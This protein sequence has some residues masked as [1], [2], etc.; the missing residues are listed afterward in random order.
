MT[1]PLSVSLHASGAENAS[2]SGTAVDVTVD[3]DAVSGVYVRGAARLRLDL[4]ALTGTSLLV[5]L[6]S[7]PSSTGPWKQIGTFAAMT[8]TGWQELVVAGGLSHLRCSWTLTGTTATFAVTGQALTIFASP[9][10]LRIPSGVSTSI[11]EEA[12]AKHLLSATGQVAGALQ[13]VNALPLTTWG[14]DVRDATAVIAT[15][16]LLD[17]IGWRPTDDFDKR[18]LQRYYNVV[19]S[20]DQNEAGW[21]DKVATGRRDPVGMV[22]STPDT[23]EAGP[24]MYSTAARGW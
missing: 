21:L 6:E 19:G 13:V 14:E 4:S 17:E 16:E 3:A 9:S 24:V 2:G 20:I 5:V 23:K 1:N 18:L 15:V 22:D 7:G 8:A 11:G 12:K 10:D